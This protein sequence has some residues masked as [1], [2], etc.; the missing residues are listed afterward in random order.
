MRA[1][2]RIQA[3]EELGRRVPQISSAATEDPGKHR[4]Q[5]APWIEQLWIEQFCLSEQKSACNGIQKIMFAAR[6]LR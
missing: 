1:I 6:E 5:L 4:P 2:C 3:V